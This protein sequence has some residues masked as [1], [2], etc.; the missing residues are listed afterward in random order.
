MQILSWIINI[1]TVIGWCVNIKRRKQAMMVFTVATMLS[2][3]YFSV[4]TQWPFLL[5]ALFFLVIDVVTL[6][7]IFK[8]EEKGL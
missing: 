7:R 5:R 2:I 1:L 4:T 3:V 6:Y 8:F